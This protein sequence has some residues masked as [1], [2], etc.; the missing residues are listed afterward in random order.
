KQM[1]ERFE[2]S[3]RRFEALQKQMDER[4]EESNRRF[5]ALQKQMDER[6]EESNRRFEALQ[7]QMDERFEESNRRFEALEERMDSRFDEMQQVIVALQ[8]SMADLSG[9]YGKRAEDA[10]RKVLGEVLEGEG[11]ETAR[12]EHIQ[13]LDRDGKV[14]GK[15]YTT[16]IDIYYE[17]KKRWI[18]EYKAR[19][20]KEN[21]MHLVMVARLMREVYRMPPDRIVMVALNVSEE[22]KA[23]AEEMGVD[24]IRGIQANPVLLPPP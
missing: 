20:D 21:I 23:F 3:N 16:D 8:V 9:K 6:F 7:K 15:G 2:E 19:A 18:I 24:V 12:I 5:E 22:A 10:L 17:G 11:I 4:F 13:V 14:F 1:D